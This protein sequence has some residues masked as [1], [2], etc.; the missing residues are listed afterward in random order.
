MKEAIVELNEEI[1]GLNSKLE[2][3]RLVTETDKT[4][5]LVILTQLGINTA[6]LKALVH[7][8]EPSNPLNKQ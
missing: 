7:Q 1:R 5:T 8:F 4:N 2:N 3:Q 6:K